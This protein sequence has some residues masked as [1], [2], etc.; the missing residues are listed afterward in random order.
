[1]GSAF[2]PTLFFSMSTFSSLLFILTVQSILFAAVNVSHNRTTAVHLH[3]SLVDKITSNKMTFFF[4]F[5][6]MVFFDTIYSH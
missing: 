4:E 3:F 6:S 1:M 5:L 2:E